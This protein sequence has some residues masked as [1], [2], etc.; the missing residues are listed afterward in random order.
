LEQI[1]RF[2]NEFHR[3][4]KTKMDYVSCYFRPQNRF[5]NLVFGG[6]ARKANN[7][8]GCSV[9]EF[10]YQH[11]TKEK[12]EENLPKGWSLAESNNEDFLKL[13]KYYEKISGG[14]T[15]T[16]LNITSSNKHLD[17]EINKEFQSI[18]L[19]RYRLFFSLKHKD[20]LIAI[21]VVSLSDLGISLSDLTNCIHLFVLKDDK[22]PSNIF[23]SSIK[24]LS[25]YYKYEKFPV[26][27]FPSNY[28]RKS[29]IPSDKTYNYWVLNVDQHSDHY[30]DHLEKLLKRSVR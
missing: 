1:G 7:N 27:I 18:G 19:K 15:L 28:V 13:E 10:A 26:L 6:V 9:D 30:F 24:E 2:I 17:E 3:L 11:I 22:L 5:P 12:L 29:S 21:F 25:K 8:K 4:P 20:K 16:A 23:N 14:L